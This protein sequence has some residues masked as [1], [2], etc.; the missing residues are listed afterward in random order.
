MTSLTSAVKTYLSGIQA[1][2]DVTL[3]GVAL[4]VWSRKLA[5]VTTVNSIQLGNVADVQ[6]RRRD[7]LIERYF[8]IAYP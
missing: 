1:A 4:V 2:I 3:D 7:N 5:L 6:N 8:P